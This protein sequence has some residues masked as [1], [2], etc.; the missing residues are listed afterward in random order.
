MSHAYTASLPNRRSGMVMLPFAGHD[1]V[2]HSRRSHA[3]L[4]SS[5]PA[6]HSTHGS[7][8]NE[9]SKEV[10]EDDKRQK[11]EQKMNHPLLCLIDISLNLSV[12]SSSSYFF[13]FFFFFFFL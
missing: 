1:S 3:P 6:E 11:D 8:P 5:N 2:G 9:K 7:F 12:S 10:W 13:F 4:T